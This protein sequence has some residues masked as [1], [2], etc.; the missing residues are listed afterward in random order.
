[1]P[2]T[3]EKPR[4]IGPDQMIASGAETSPAFPSDGKLAYV[5]DKLGNTRPYTMIRSHGNKW[6]VHFEGDKKASTV[7]MVNGQYVIIQDE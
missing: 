1:M 6:R 5:L 3:M 4:P 7:K 2:E